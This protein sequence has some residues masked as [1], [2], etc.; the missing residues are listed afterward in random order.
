V[1]DL[2]HALDPFRQ[3]NPDCDL[4][5]LLRP[6]NAAKKFISSIGKNAC[7]IHQEE[8]LLKTFATVCTTAI[9]NPLLR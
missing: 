8:L 4:P 3:N 7:F 5:L 1:S 9:L 6:G 2:D